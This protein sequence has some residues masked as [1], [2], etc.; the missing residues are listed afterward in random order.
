V[1]YTGS[2]GLI[3]KTTNGGTNFDVLPTITSNSLNCV[4][5]SGTNVGWIVGDNGV[6][7]KTTT[8]G[9]TFE[10][11]STVDIPSNFKLFQNYPNPFNPNTIIRY[12]IPRGSP[13]GAFGDDKVTLKVY[14][15][16][17]REI[18]TLVNENLKPGTYEVKFDGSKL[19]SGVYFYKLQAGD[20]QETK[21]L[22]LLK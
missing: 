6:I 8:G 5:F 12:T 14:D 21:K 22:I 10:Q 4:R 20:F 19:A 3:A 18:E 2:A 9:I 13:I 11:E 7:L 15:I 17:G 16:I 1:G